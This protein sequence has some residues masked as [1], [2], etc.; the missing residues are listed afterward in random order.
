[1]DDFD[2]IKVREFLNI[3]FNETD[4]IHISGSKNKL[5]ISVTTST[6]RK[7]FKPKVPFNVK[8]NGTLGWFDE[9]LN[10]CLLPMR[11]NKYELRNG[12]NR[13]KSIRPLH[14]IFN[15]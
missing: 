12:C 4:D 9:E 8:N 2:L 6:G 14:A 15:D 11:D 7:V 3:L 13:N 10:L 5:I 1:M